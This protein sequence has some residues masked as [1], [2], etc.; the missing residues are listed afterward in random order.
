LILKEDIADYIFIY[1]YQRKIGLILYP[2][3]ITRSNIAFTAA[4][5]FSFLI[6]LSLN[7]IAAANRYI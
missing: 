2:V 4:R 3:I 5:L 7:Y 6:N 1:L